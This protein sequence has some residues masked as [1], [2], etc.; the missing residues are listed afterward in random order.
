MWNSIYTLKTGLQNVQIF[1]FLKQLL[2]IAQLHQSP[3]NSMFK[4]FEL[5]LGACQ[6]STNLIVMA[7]LWAK[8][9]AWMQPTNFMRRYRGH[10]N[11]WLF[12]GTF[13][14]SEMQFKLLKE[15]KIKKFRASFKVQWGRQK[16]CLRVK[17][18]L[19]VSLC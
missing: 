19:F 17:L 1:F 8:I 15:Q 3:K 16:K 5:L 14:L 12:P 10:Y 4:K 18:F 6:M 7:A 2:L 13:F 11:H 9:Q